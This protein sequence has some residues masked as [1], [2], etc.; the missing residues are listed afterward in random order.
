MNNAIRI[1]T[2][3]NGQLLQAAPLDGFRIESD[4]EL[5][6]KREYAVREDARKRN[7][8]YYVTSYHEPVRS[9][10]TLL[11]LNELGAVMKLIPYMHMD[12]AGDLY[13]NGKRMSTA[14]I[15][16]VIGK[17]ARMTATIVAS[18][19]KYG[20]LTEDKEGRRK[21]YAIHPEYHTIGRA[22]KQGE[23]FTKIYQMKTRSDVKNLSIQA[24]GLLYCMIPFFHYRLCYLCTNPD[25]RKADKLDVITQASLARFLGVDDQTVR[26][27]L[28]E[29]SKNGFIMRSESLGVTVIKVNP[30]VMY[31]QKFD[32]DEYTQALRYD[33][34]QHRK[35]SESGHGLDDADLP[36]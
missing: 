9:L 10:T 2:D 22:L 3:E 35:A 25:E 36:F 24:A 30:D 11:S 31:R 19:V 15:S 21:V 18:L 34:E 26:R 6:R 5:A 1:I 23:S 8:K 12:N 28:R 17:A 14:E 27:G 7:T 33:F 32:D 4:D 16:K 29:L 13:L 20:I